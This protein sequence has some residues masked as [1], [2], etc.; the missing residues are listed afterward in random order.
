[1]SKSLYLSRTFQY[2]ASK[3]LKWNNWVPAHGPTGRR[4]MIL[5]LLLKC[6]YNVDVATAVIQGED[7]ARLFF[8]VRVSTKGGD[9]W[10]LPGE[11]SR[12]MSNVLMGPMR[13]FEGADVA[14]ATPSTGEHA[15]WIPFA[16]PFAR[17][18]YDFAI[19]AD[20][21]REVEITCPSQ[22]DLDLGTSAVTINA[23]T[24][25][26]I[27][28]VCREADAVEIPMY[29]VIGETA[30]ETLTQGTIHVGG[31]YL[32]EAV[33]YA[34]GTPG[35]AAMT[36]WTDHRIPSL[37]NDPLLA[38]DWK[39]LYNLRNSAAPQDDATPGTELLNDPVKQNRA[40]IVHLPG[41]YGDD[42]LVD[43]P[44]VSGALIVK[45]T[46]SVADVKI[47]HRVIYPTPENERRF[48]ASAHRVAKGRIKTAGKTRR[49]PQ[50]WGK[51]APYMPWSG[52]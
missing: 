2:A 24:S 48:V 6:S 44:F 11:G 13:S 29:D 17:R 26:S 28:A 47:A 23:A 19:A 49:A 8:N 40:R 41:G 12:I 16:K 27:L 3:P 7:L 5:G 38:A 22:A 45:A 10:N 33:A 15:L 50:D 31:G 51:K 32:A 46:N 14:V 18:W 21:L 39:F 43:L 1:M 42:K 20:V 52:K 34:A 25:Y 9:R 30:M 4:N 37:L 35:G 36:N